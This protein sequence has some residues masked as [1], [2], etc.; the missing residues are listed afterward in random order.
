LRRQQHESDLAVADF[1]FAGAD[2]LVVPAGMG[3]SVTACIWNVS[4]STGLGE[5]MFCDS[6]HRVLHSSHFAAAVVANKSLVG[7]TAVSRFV[8][9][10]DLEI[11]P[12]SCEVSV[13]YLTTHKQ[14]GR[15]SL[16]PEFAE[17][18]QASHS[19]VT[20]HQSSFGGVW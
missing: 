1:P 19:T 16:P 14:V 20:N 9:F 18:T 12:V 5:K 10:S 17:I 4:P 15:V 7:Y 6:R 2:L 3:S 8:W 13:W 11:K